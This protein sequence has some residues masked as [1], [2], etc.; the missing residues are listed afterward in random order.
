MYTSSANT[1]TINAVLG[2]TSFIHTFGF[3]PTQGTG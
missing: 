1:S 3:A 2:D